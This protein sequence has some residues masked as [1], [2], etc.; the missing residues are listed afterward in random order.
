VGA[1]KLVFQSDGK[2]SAQFEQTLLVTETGVEILTE[3]SSKRPWFMDQ[4]EKSYS[5]SGA[6]SRS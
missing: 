2:P 1:K 4:L 5:N 6:G 3:R